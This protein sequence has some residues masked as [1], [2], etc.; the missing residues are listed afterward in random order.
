[1]SRTQKKYFED[2]ASSVASLSY[3]KKRGLKK[4]VRTVEICP[5]TL[6]PREACSVRNLSFKRVCS[7]TLEACRN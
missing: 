7:F 5:F 2:N 1:M 4:L 3:R 6:E